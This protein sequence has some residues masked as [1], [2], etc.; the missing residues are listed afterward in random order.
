[1]RHASVLG[2]RLFNT[3]IYDLV[4]LIGIKDFNNYTDCLTGGAPYKGERS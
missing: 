3:Y 4:Y 1:M 2:P